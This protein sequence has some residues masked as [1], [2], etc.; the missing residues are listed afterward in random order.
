A[1]LDQKVERSRVE[2]L[3]EP[4][5]EFID[6]K[7]HHDSLLKDQLHSDYFKVIHSIPKYLA[8]KL[9]IPLSEIV[10]TPSRYEHQ[11][12]NSWQEFF[13]KMF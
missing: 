2:K 4:F 5:F 8:K 7:T 9:E 6:Y 12:E 11:P 3:L 1:S 10:K 13:W